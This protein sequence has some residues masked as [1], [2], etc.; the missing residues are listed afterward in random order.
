MATTASTKA[1]SRDRPVSCM[2]TVVPLGTRVFGGARPIWRLYSSMRAASSDWATPSA[3]FVAIV[4]SRERF[5]RLIRTAPSPS[6][7]LATFVMGVRCPEALR[8]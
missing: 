6:W 1:N 7:M 2:I 4:I 5:C 8:I 3:P